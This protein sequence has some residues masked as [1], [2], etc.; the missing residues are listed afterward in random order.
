MK[1]QI[2]SNKLVMKLMHKLDRYDKKE[3]VFIWYLV[4]L[5][6]CILFFPILRKSWSAYSDWSEFFWIY[7]F[8]SC[9]FIT[10]LSM[11]VLIWRNLSY[12]FK[13]TF[14]TYFWWR[15]N[16]SLINFLF[17]FVISVVYFGI[18]SATTIIN[19][20]VTQSIS[21]SKRAYF[22][23]F[24]LLIWMIITVLSMIK[25]AKEMSKKTRIINMVDETKEKDNEIKEEIKKGLFEE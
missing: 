9:F 11:I 5:L 6:V 16:N 15:D 24:V 1:N 22:T 3:K 20:E 18:I 21:V 14:I 19:N 7:K 13:N 4:L 25:S 12:R 8:T 2:K 23:I 10:I 17:L